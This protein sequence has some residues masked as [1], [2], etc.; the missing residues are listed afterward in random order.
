MKFVN[1]IL[2]VSIIFYLSHASA[3][4][5]VVATTSDISSLVGE[6]GGDDIELDAIAKGTQDPHTI[7]PKPSFMLKMSK[8]DLVVANG[9]SLE[10]GWLP[11]LIQGARNPK[12]R[13]DA[14]GY[15][16]LGP[17]ADPID[18]P[19]AAVTRAMGDVHPDGNPHYTLDPI[20]TG[21][22]ALVIAEKLGSLDP[23][24]KTKYVERAS[25]FKTK[26]ELKAKDWQERIKK[27]GITKVVTYH[28]SLNY[29]LD[30][31]GIQGVAFLEPKPG[32]PPTAHHILSVMEIVK[33]QKVPLILV[34]NF[35]DPKI[36]GRIVQ[37]V[38]SVQ[39][40]TVGIAV[41]SS[42]ELK[43]LFDVTENLVIAIERKK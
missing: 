13:S 6:V 27:S 35:Y 24:K 7:D 18:L 19:R 28:P 25:A 29:F 37:E 4:L 1:S 38:P 26:M 8:A 11:S 15:L 14:P 20:R 22:L 43:N 21:K 34:D 42:P 39:V 31:F 23:D 3:K 10:V 5:H 16:D 30:R 40:R 17:S 2:A 12:I 33:Q 41:G 9:L 32:I 36:A